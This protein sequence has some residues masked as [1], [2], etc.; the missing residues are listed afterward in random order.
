MGYKKGDTVNISDAFE[1]YGYSLY[2]NLQSQNID[3]IFRRFHGR[4]DRR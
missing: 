2:F 1:S 4:Q 3:D